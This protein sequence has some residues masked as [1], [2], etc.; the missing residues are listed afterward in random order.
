ML[1]CALGHST[2]LLSSGGRG[3]CAGLAS[4][5][6]TH[7]AAHTM[8]SLTTTSNLLRASL[9]ALVCVCVCNMRIRVCVVRCGTSAA[10]RSSGTA[11]GTTGASR[12][13][14]STR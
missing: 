8:L 10:A 11:G 9:C 6:R 3:V 4:V 13:W 1:D 14:S 12:A 2:G 7:P 5:P